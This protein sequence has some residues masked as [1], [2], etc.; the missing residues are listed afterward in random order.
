M[1]DDRACARCALGGWFLHGE[2]QSPCD[3]HAHN[4]EQQKAGTGNSQRL[5]R[6]TMQN[7][8]GCKTD[9]HAHRGK[10]GGGGSGR[11]QLR[12]S[13]QGE[14]TESK[15]HHQACHGCCCHPPWDAEQASERGILHDARCRHEE[16][17]E[18]IQECNASGEDH[19]IRALRFPRCDEGAAGSCA[20]DERKAVAQPRLAAN[21]SWCQAEK[22]LRFRDHCSSRDAKAKSDHVQPAQRLTEERPTQQCCNYHV[23]ALQC[24][25]L[26]ERSTCDYG[27]KQTGVSKTAE[28]S[29]HTNPLHLVRT[30]LGPTLLIMR[31]GRKQRRHC[32]DRNA[33]ECEEGE[34][35]PLQHI[36]HDYH[37][38]HSK[39]SHSHQ[40]HPST[41]TC[42]HACKFD[43]MRGCLRPVRRL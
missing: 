4:P 9:R 1:D 13:A 34:L 23:D 12:T 36:L 10:Y 29:A 30:Q 3:C 22:H 41:F 2:G 40:Y 14:R 32:E 39:A 17:H 16:E 27:E 26:A 11:A 25:G 37:H 28:E 20:G 19:R 38:R 33:H 31:D 18:P 24:T 42:Y 7:C 21:R 8:L 5:W 43:A 35:E 6:F 15:R